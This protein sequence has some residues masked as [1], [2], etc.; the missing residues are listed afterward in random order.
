VRT[1]YA[2][3]SIYQV[4]LKSQLSSEYKK[5][6]AIQNIEIVNLLTLSVIL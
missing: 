4:D 2:L 5:E 1:S 3:Q 6:T